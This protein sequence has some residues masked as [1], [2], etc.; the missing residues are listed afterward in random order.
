MTDDTDYLNELA[1]EEDGQDPWQ[2]G[3]IARTILCS[4]TPLAAARELARTID[5]E[6]LSIFVGETDE[7]LALGFLMLT[8]HEFMP[9]AMQ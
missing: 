4:P 5:R 9:A 2:R 8:F 6:S 1:A 7:E 3:R